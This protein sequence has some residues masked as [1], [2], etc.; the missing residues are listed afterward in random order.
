LAETLQKSKEA[1]ISDQK[2]R[3]IK[4]QNPFFKSS[5]LKIIVYRSTE[6]YSVYSVVTFIPIVGYKIKKPILPWN[7]GSLAINA[8]SPFQI[9]EAAP[10]Q[11]LPF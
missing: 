2:Y 1:Y 8:I 5:R 6:N 10:F 3:K 9:R 11:V 4:N 7:T